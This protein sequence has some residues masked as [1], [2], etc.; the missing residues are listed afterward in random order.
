MVDTTY[1]MPGR[2]PRR[3][4]DRLPQRHDL[5]ARAQRRRG[6]P[7]QR[8]PGLDPARR[9]PAASCSRCCSTASPRPTPTSRRRRRRFFEQLAA[10]RKLLTVPAD[11]GRGRQAGAALRRT[12]RSARS[13]SSRSG[14]RTVFDFGEW[15]SEVASRHN[16][17]GTVSFITIAPGFSGLRVR[18]GH[19]RRSGRS[20][21]RDA[22]HE[23]GLRCRRVG[24]FVEIGTLSGC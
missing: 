4:H 9:L 11:R 5:A 22:Q 24:D 3:R 7:D 21:S 20:S 10:E 23:Y 13:R 12:T 6:D 19:G 18:R 17:D 8:R 15:K 1:G 14:R 16:P 2:A